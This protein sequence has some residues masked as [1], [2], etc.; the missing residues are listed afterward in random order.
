MSLDL[1]SQRD[2]KTWT[3]KKKKGA[4]HKRSRVG[5]RKINKE[6]LTIETVLVLNDAKKS[7]ISFSMKTVQWFH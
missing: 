5:D 3:G 4:R 6:E 1:S 7:F 2:R